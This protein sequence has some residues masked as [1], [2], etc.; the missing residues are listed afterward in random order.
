M[1]VAIAFSSCQDEYPEITGPD[2][3]IAISDNRNVAGLALKTVPK[4]G[5]FDNIVDK[6]CENGIGF[7]YPV[8]IKDELVETT[9]LEDIGTQKYAKT[10]EPLLETQEN[11]LARLGNNWKI[12]SINSATIEMEAGSGSG[13]SK[14]QLILSNTEKLTLNLVFNALWGL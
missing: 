6:C 14:K 13:P 7:P 5:A 9:L 10:L 2:K 11:L 1:E 8:T 3:R 4:D 12:N